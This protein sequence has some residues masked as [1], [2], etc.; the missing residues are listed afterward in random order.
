MAQGVQLFR[1]TTS[2]TADGSTPSTLFTLTGVTAA[3]IILNQLVVQ[4]SNSW[5]SSFPYLLLTLNSAN[6]YSSPLWMSRGPQ[7]YYSYCAQ[8]IDHPV[9]VNPVNGSYLANALPGNA[10]FATSLSSAPY[11]TDSSSIGNF[12]YT[13][14]YPVRNFYMGPS[15]SVT[16]RFYAGNA[17][18]AN[19]GYSF[20]AIT[21][22]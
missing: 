13:D 22:F 14:G 6:S 7:N 3:R 4:K 18:S 5:G 17:G 8:I 16:V 21:E 11:F 2:V 20:T 12:G 1:G 10:V 9:G 19:V 15:D